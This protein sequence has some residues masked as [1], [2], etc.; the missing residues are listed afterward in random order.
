VNLEPLFTERIDYD[1]LEAMT[2]MRNGGWAYPVG[3]TPEQMRSEA[4]EYYHKE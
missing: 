3:S 4:I 2:D 1:E